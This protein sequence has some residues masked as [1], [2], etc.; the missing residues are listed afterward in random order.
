MTGVCLKRVIR[1]KKK[2]T[3]F[4]CLIC[5]SLLRKWRKM[6]REWSGGVWGEDWFGEDPLWR[7]KQN[8]FLSSSHGGRPSPKQCMRK[9]GHFYLFFAKWQ[10]VDMFSCL[11]RL[12]FVVPSGLINGLNPGIINNV[13]N[14]IWC[15]N[16]CFDWRLVLDL[17]LEERVVFGAFWSF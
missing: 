10:Q 5:V 15:L 16:L 14:K 4:R 6:D 7:W 3:F 11:L 13:R 17:D 9:T 2:K 8:G 1:F 12:L